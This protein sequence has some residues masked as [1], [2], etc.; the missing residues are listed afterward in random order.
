MQPMIDAEL[1][2]GIVVGLYDAGK[3]RSTA[4]AKVPAASRRHGSTLF[5]LGP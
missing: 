2:S 3:P 5:E 1:T 4:L